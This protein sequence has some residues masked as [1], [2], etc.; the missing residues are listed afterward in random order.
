VSRPVQSH[1]RAA[2]AWS[3]ARTL[4]G[5]SRNAY[6]PALAMGAYSNPST[7]AERAFAPGSEVH[8][9][10]DGARGAVFRV[11]R[12]IGRGGMGEVY[13]VCCQDDGQRYALKCLRI[14]QAQNARTIERTRREAFTLQSLRH[15]N[16]VRVHAT[17]VRE[18]GLIWMVMDLLEATRWPR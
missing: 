1:V 18:D 4:P 16:L 5:R 8:G 17:G 9:D 6:A 12:S 3:S 10:A 13:E 2:R 11:V 15:P 14:E 7:W